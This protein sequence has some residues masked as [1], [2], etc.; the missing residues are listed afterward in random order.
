MLISA[1]F[2]QDQ[3]HQLS[4]FIE[5]TAF[6]GSSSIERHIASIK[7]TTLNLDHIVLGITTN[8]QI[9]GWLSMGASKD[10]GETE[11]LIR[12]YLDCIVIKDS[13]RNKGIAS[14]ALED[15]AEFLACII[16]ASLPDLGSNTLPLDIEFSAIFVNPAGEACVKYF[17]ETVFKSLSYKLNESCFVVREFVDDTSSGF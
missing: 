5:V 16:E 6:G 15:A 9:S 10:I 1:P 2:D 7:Q 17:G 13:F 8:S 4:E 11:S 12:I 3:Q 14:L